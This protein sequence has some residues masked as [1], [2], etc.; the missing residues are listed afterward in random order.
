MP[1]VDCLFCRIP[2]DGVA[3]RE[4]GHTGLRCPRCGLIFVSPRPTDE[5]VAGRYAHDGAH[6]D[7]AWHVA[8]ERT[9]RLRAR[10]N[11]RIIWSHERAGRLLEL[12]S[13]AGHFLDEARE[14]GYDARGVEPNVELARYA[15]ETVGVACAD[16]PLEQSPYGG[17]T[18]DIAYHADV[19]SHLPDPVDTFRRIRARL[20][21]GGLMVFETGN[22]A[23]VAPE[24]LGYVTSF[25]YPDHLCFY[26]VAHLRS[27][28]NATGFEVV[29]VR[30]Y[31]LM[32]QILGMRW[33]SKAKSV[34]RGGGAPTAVASPTTSAPRAGGRMRDYVS[35]LLVYACGSLAP[36]RR[37][38]Q[39][40]IVV[41]RA[42]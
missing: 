41:A 18:F 28:L 26:R 5:E 22:L 30:R 8:A 11:L 16:L 24:Y 23:E 4:S 3:I 19:L 9:R 20:R 25:Q 38:P 17:M 10:H 34:I 32:P 39:T 15:R 36:K 42:T 31:S 21:D 35:H 40:V 14:A 29:A 37:R 33:L 1:D 6:V 2:G 13:G 27:L 7:A 12:G